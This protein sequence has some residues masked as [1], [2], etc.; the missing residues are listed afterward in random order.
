MI[1][2]NRL[3]KWEANFKEFVSRQLQ[4]FNLAA[5]EWI[6]ERKPKEVDDIKYDLML[7]RIHGWLV[8]ASANHDLTST[9]LGK[10]LEV[11]GVVY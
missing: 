8:M 7:T 10:N 1:E 2:R 9:S 3:I 6:L 4:M 11:K 5:I